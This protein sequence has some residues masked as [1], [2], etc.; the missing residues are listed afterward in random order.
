MVDGVRGPDLIAAASPAS[1]LPFGL[2]LSNHLCAST[3]HQM[4]YGEHLGATQSSVRWLPAKYGAGTASKE[5]DFGNRDKKLET[6]NARL[7]S[8]GMYY[9]KYMHCHKQT[10]MKLQV[11]CTAVNNP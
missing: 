8:Q 4:S 7:P 11:L 10:H 6:K 3:A 1:L 9:N 5:A 2:S